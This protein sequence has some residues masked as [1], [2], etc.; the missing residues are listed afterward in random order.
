MKNLEVKTSVR[1]DISISFWTTRE[2]WT[3]LM[4]REREQQRSSAFLSR[5]SIAG[6]GGWHLGTGQDSG[7]E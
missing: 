1:P 4:G 3:W 7:G 6:G 2:V 5:N